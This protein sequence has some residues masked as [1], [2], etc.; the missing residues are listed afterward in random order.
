MIK[1]VNVVTTN[2]ETTITT[3]TTVTQH[4]ILT[5]PGNS[6]EITLVDTSVSTT[7]IYPITTTPQPAGSNIYRQIESTNEIDQTFG[8]GKM[9]T[10]LK[11]RFRRLIFDWDPKNSSSGQSETYTPIMTILNGKDA[12]LVLHLDIKEEPKEIVFEFDN[13]TA[14]NFLDLDKE[15]I[16]SSLGVTTATNKTNHTLKISCKGEFAQE[17]TLFARAFKKD[18]ADG[19]IDPKGEICA[20][21]RILP[22]APQF[23]FKPKVVLIPCQTFLQGTNPVTGS[24][25]ADASLKLE[26]ILGQAL[27]FP[28]IET[29]PNPFDLTQPPDNFNSLYCHEITPAVPAVPAV[30]ATAT[31]PAVPAIPAVPAVYDAIDEKK[32]EDMKVFL[33]DKLRAD[34]AGKYEHY[35]KIFLFEEDLNESTAGY[36]YGE[37]YIVCFKAINTDNNL[38]AHELLHGLELAHPFDGA[39]RN[40]PFTYKY[41]TTDNIMD[42]SDTEPPNPNV[43]CLY[44]WQWQI[45]NPKIR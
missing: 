5:I 25:P 32:F 31:T 43:K 20:M 4:G 27:V 9:Y 19:T 28:E 45:I 10:R 17:Y 36:S 16:T 21:L 1:D 40:T 2:T 3:T 18:A 12:D 15:K 7:T 14:K 8:G 41:A 23:H 29:L 38:A 33:L 13:S 35:Y 39:S 24:M 44:H 42:Y 6:H 34:Y 37:K 30:P 11:H 26:N 22:N